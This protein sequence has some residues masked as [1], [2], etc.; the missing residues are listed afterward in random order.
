MLYVVVKKCANKGRTCSYLPSKRGGPRKKK[1]T[2]PPTTDPDELVQ[3]S[4]WDPPIV[5]NAPYEEGE[6]T[7]VLP[8]NWSPIDV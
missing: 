8:L 2:V 5:Q 1:S 4:S 7:P 3:D 6:Q